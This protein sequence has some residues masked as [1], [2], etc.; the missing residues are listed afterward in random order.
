MGDSSFGM[1][2]FGINAV[3]GNI[4]LLLLLLFVVILHA[5][6]PE[7]IDSYLILSYQLPNLSITTGFSV[8]DHA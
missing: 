6:L 2:G 7:K 8:T 3:C 1:V 4:L 5:H